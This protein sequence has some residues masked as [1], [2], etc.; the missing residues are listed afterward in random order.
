MIITDGIHIT[1]TESLDELHSCMSRIGI[2]RYWF[3]GLKRGHPHYNKPKSVTVHQLVDRGVIVVRPRD[4]LMACK[5]IA[6]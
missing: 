1:S 6:R 3:E 2:G 5:R 4:V